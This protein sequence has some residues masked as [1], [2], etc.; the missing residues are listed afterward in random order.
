M[1]GGVCRDKSPAGKIKRPRFA[2][3]LTKERWIFERQSFLASTFSFVERVR[4]SYWT[5]GWW[6]TWGAWATCGSGTWMLNVV[7]WSKS[8]R[9][10]SKLK[11]PQDTRYTFHAPGIITSGFLIVQDSKLKK[12][13]YCTFLWIL[14]ALLDVHGAWLQ[15]NNRCANKQYFVPSFFR[16]CSVSL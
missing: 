13:K 16:A 9:R 2:S 3:V 11:A 10:E 15:Y 12:K 1:N 4:S 14:N 8:D 5:C 6:L 7:G